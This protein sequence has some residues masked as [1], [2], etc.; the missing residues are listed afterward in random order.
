MTIFFKHDIYGMTTGTMVSIFGGT[1]LVASEY[2]ESLV[3]RGY[4]ITRYEN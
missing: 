2:G 1:W 3:C 4:D